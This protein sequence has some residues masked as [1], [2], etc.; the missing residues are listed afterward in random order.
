MELETLFRRLEGVRA[1]AWAPGHPFV[2]PHR[3]LGEVL[4]LLAEYDPA[5]AE[6]AEGLVELSEEALAQRLAAAL[7]GAAGGSEAEAFVLQAMLRAYARG[8]AEDTEAEGARCPVCGGLADVAYLDQD[9]FR[10]LVC[11][12][13]DSRWPAPRIGCPYC[14]ETDAKKLHYY[15]YD[16]HY[17]LYECQTCG[18]TLPAVDLR[19]AGRLNLPRLRAAAVE[20][21]FL[22][23]SGAVEG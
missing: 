17:R 8:L 5:A 22:L 3:V 15:P 18:A 16:P 10:H 6:K 23:E 7:E 11:G 13:C 9:G 14:G 1:P 20:M 12:V 19:E 21:R 4:N 2:A